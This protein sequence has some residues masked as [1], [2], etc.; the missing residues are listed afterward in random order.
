MASSFLNNLSSTY[1]QSPSLRNQFATEQDYLDLFDNQNV[2]PAMAKAYVPTN[3]TTGIKSI[4]N[5]ATPIINQGGGD[6]GNGPPDGPTDPGVTADDYGLGVDDPTGMGYELTDKDKSDI[7]GQKTKNTAMG[8]MAA[9]SFAFNPV[10]FFIGRYAKDKYKEY[11]EKKEKQDAIDKAKAEA[12]KAVAEGRAYDYEGRDNQYGTHTSTMTNAQAQ[13]N[14]DRGRGNTGTRSGKPG[15][16]AGFGAS[17]HKADG[18]LIYADGGRVGYRSGGFSVLGSSSMTDAV[19]KR[20]EALM[21][22]GLDFGSAYT[23]VKKEAPAL[24]HGGR[25]KSNNSG[26]LTE[27]VKSKLMED[28]SQGLPAVQG[29]AIGMPSDQDGIISISRR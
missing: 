25:V 20:I 24:A 5:T 8:L 18:G 6:G 14:Q 19:M 3:D 10:G 7:S 16:S 17:F 15:G 29:I 2:T 22:E 1:R 12:D 9:L 13:A 23:Q 26:S 4:I 28:D 27:F 11:K 21:D